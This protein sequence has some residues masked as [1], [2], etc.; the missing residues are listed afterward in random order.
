MSASAALTSQLKTLKLG[1]MLDTLDVRLLQARQD[2]LGY[3]EFLQLLLQDEIE[4]RKTQSLRLRLQRASFEE[5]KTLEEFDF[6]GSPTLNPA[7]IRDL[8]TGLFIERR[9]HVL[10]YGPAGTGK[11]H[12]AQALGHH[13]CRSGRSVLFLKAVKLFRTL[14]SSRADNSWDAEL[15]RLLAPDLLIIDDFG[16]KPMT[17]TQAGSSLF[18]VG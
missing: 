1:R 4:R 6:A 7:A 13:A 5:P 17:M 16:L 10:L 12:L 8:A 3:L 9:E 18:Q 2:Q 14:Q 15:R 11:T